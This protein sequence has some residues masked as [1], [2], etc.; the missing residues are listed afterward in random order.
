MTDARH[1]LRFAT[2]AHGRLGWREAGAAN[3]APALVLLHGI[4]ST[5][6]G[7]RLQ[8][9]PLGER[10]RVLAWDAPGYGGSTPL[11]GDSPSPEAYAQALESARSE[12]QGREAGRTAQTL[13]GARV[14][15]VHAPVLDPH[16]HTR[17]RC[18]AVQHH[19][20]VQ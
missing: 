18:H 9:G 2:L 4:G 19:H 17:E 14:G 15:R 20:R 3:G 13:L 6:A 16:V 11:P 5:S 10:F 7:W 8:Y 12:D 1:P